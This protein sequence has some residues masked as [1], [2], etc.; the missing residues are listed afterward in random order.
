MTGAEKNLFPGLPGYNTAQMGADRRKS[1]KLAGTHLQDHSGMAPEWKE[2]DLTR[3]DLGAGNRYCSLV[4]AL[5]PKRQV[6]PERP[7]RSAHEGGPDGAGGGNDDHT[8]AAECILGVHAEISKLFVSLPQ[9][10]QLSM[11]EFTIT[12]MRKICSKI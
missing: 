9:N 2:K 5:F 8:P 12:L 7:D 6:I 11:E 3:T 4:R 10:R 1:S